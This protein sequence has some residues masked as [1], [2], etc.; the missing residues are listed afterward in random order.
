MT[1]R[2]SKAN[3]VI[4]SDIFSSHCF[5]TSTLST[6]CQ[7][8]QTRALIHSR[9]INP[10][11]TKHSRPVLSLAKNGRRITPKV[12]AV[13]NTASAIGVLLLALILARYRSAAGNGLDEGVDTEDTAPLL[14]HTALVLM[15][16]SRGG[17]C[18]GQRWVVGVKRS[19]S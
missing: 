19:A 1:P 14:E 9:V 11:A 6:T 15:R 17:C 5:V 2:F 12:L 16:M 3:L 18:R 8:H 7:L 10:L 4:N 13:G